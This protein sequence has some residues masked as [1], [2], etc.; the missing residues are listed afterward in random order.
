MRPPRHYSGFT[1]IELMIS[2][3][4]LAVLM[5]LALPSFRD[6]FEKARLRGA[7]DDIS[8]FVARQRLN[9]VRLDRE[10]SLS[11]RGDAGV[12]CVGAR[13]AANPANPGES[14]PAAE[15]CDCSTDAAECLVAGESA[16]VASTSYGAA[17]NQPTIDA[18]DIL[19]TFDGRRGTL[20]D[21][22]DAGD[23]ELSS[24][25]GRWKLRVEVLGL[26]Q[27]RVCVPDTSLGMGGYVSC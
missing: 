1:L 27:A 19:L 3:A 2:I 9:S 25:S 26:G 4:V 13:V 17:G 7:A 14:V 23:V 5:A 11:V 22:D 24:S 16:V 8:G 6:F 12:W 10:V 18:A 21:F 20:T 15:E